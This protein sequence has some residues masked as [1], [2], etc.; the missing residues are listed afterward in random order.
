MKNTL[1]LAIGT[2]TLI[3]ATNF[4]S[5]GEELLSPRAK[6]NQTRTVP[7]VTEDKLDRSI[8]TSSP[9]A[10][11]LDYSLRKMSGTTEDRLDRSLVIMSPKERALQSPSAKEYQVAPLK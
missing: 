2:A 11:E 4:V 7:G 8:Q 10:R 3:T 6:S 1:L 5:A 9:K